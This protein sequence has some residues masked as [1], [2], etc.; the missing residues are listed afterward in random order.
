MI[1]IS[2]MISNCEH[3]FM[4]LMAICISSLEKCLFRFSAYLLNHIVW[5]FFVVVVVVVSFMLLYELFIYF[6][7]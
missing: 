2:M 6:L 4:C 3:V 7:Y 5:V 1:C